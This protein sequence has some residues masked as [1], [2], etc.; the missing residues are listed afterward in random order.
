MTSTLTPLTWAQLY[1][2]HGLPVLPLHWVEDGACSCGTDCGNNAAKHPRTRRGKD[3]ATTEPA[4]INEWWTRWP[5]ANVG[6]RPPQGVVVLDV[7]PRNG[8]DTALAKLTQQHDGLPS[9]L[10]AQ[11]G[12]GGHHIW[13]KYLGPCRGH[14]LP[15]ID[16]KASTGYLV[17]EPSQHISGRSYRW[18]TTHPLAPAPEWLR[19][20]I[21]PAPLSLKP[22]PRAASHLRGADAGLVRKVANALEGNRNSSLYWA[23]CRVH[24]RGGDPALL[25]DLVSAAVAAGLTEPASR[26]TTASAGAA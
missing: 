8:G 24:E 1:A 16:L 6:V 20:L 21:T 25:E 23:A 3:D 5:H 9:T 22:P 7:D 14:L 18:A 26:A 17:A 13:Y 10:V 12:G 2:A 11:T 4:V 15:G 19:R